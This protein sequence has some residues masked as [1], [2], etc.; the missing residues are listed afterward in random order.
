MKLKAGQFGI[1]NLI[2]QVDSEMKAKQYNLSDLTTASAIFK[3]VKKNLKGEMFIDWEAELTSE[4]K[5]FLTKLIDE[6]T[7]TVND[8]EIVFELKELIK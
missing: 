6:R 3:E 5:V 7:W 8:A 2:L 4:Q 1:I